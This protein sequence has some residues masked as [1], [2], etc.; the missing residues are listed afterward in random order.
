MG[1]SKNRATID[2]NGK[3][4]RLG[5]DY[6]RDQETLEVWVGKIVVNEDPR[7]RIATYAP[8]VQEAMV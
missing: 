6:G 1:Y 3:P 7:P 8:P 5:H 4:M 2:V